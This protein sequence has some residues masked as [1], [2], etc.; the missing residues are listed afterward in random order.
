MIRTLTTL[1]LGLLVLAGC[2][3]EPPPAAPPVEFDSP[4]AFLDAQDG[5]LV[6]LLVGMEGCAK[7]MAGTKLLAGMASDLPEGVVIARVDAPP[8]GGSIEAV[9]K[10]P[11]AYYYDVDPERDVADRLDFF[12]Y[13]TLYLLDGEGEVRF[14]GGC[15]DR[16]AIEEMVAAIRAEKPGDA[17]NVYTAPLKAV[18]DAAPGIAAKGP[19]GEKVT[20]ENFEAEG[21]TLLFFNSIGCPFSAKAVAGLPDLEADF[22]DHKVAYVVVEQA[23]AA[24]RVKEF[25]EETDVPGVV[26]HDADGA[27]CKAYGVEPAP[28]F[29]VLDDTGTVAARGPYTEAAAKKALS[30]VLGIKGGCGGGETSGAG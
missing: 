24:A 3:K 29:Y 20:F 7:T 17:K 14:A 28:F 18:G 12:Y 16:K 27:V 13:P 19:D 26:V 6:V 21:P 5:K 25:Y 22:E 9:E 10:W 30:D 1:A 8:P 11:H 4:E 2:G 15:D 23:R